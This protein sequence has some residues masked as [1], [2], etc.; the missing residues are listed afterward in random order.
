MKSHWFIIFIIFLLSG[1]TSKEKLA[2]YQWESSGN[3]DFDSVTIRLEWDFNE[4]API[5]SIRRGIDRLC[6]IA[7]HANG[8]RRPLLESRICY[9]K[10]KYHSRTGDLDSCRIYLDRALELNDSSANP[11]DYHRFKFH[12]A[13]NDPAIDGAEEYRTYNECL[14]F[15]RSSSDIATEAMVSINMGNLLRQLRESQKALMFLDRADSLNSIL[16]FT[17]FTVKNKINKALLLRGLGRRNEADSIF[18]Y[19]DRHPVI[20]EDKATHVLILRHLYYSSGK[21][22]FLDRAQTIINKSSKQEHLRGYI[23]NLK[24]DYWLRQPVRLDSAL[25]YSD[26]ALR[27]CTLIPDLYLQAEIYQNRSRAMYLV[28]RNDSAYLY[29][30]TSDNLFDSI[31]RV[32]R[33]IEIIKMSA[34]RE[35]GL[36]E[37][38]HSRELYR[39]NLLIAIVMLL[40]VAAVGFTL[41]ILNRRQL[42]QKIK[43]M[44][45][46]ITLEKT[47]RKMSASALAIQQNDNVLSVLSDELSEMR[48]EGTIADANARK[49]ESTIK[50]HLSERDTDNVVSDMLDIVHPQ[51]IDR[52]HARCG[53]LADSYDKIACYILMGLDNK[54][55]GRLMMIKP[56]SVRQA[57]W[58][59]RQKLNLAEGETMEDVLRRMNT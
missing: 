16:G 32:N 6:R 13:S 51:F 14:D 15:A 2:P 46:E 53:E 31:E 7:A 21:L 9:W 11:Y 33:D 38:R 10:A 30:V 49:L 40:S 22:E 3:P 59:L 27:E 54:K 39:R 41:F 52:L 45:T 20:E 29:R 58:R 24:A 1:C 18:R 48:R 8:G 43:A 36:A 5:D 17:K 57:R 44:E 26:A 28:G 34:L 55:I 12:K 25:Y 23:L 56:E 19:L 4:Y 37:A 47:K 50:T 42:R 35:Y